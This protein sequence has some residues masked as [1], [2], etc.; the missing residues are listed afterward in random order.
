MRK[1]DDLGFETGLSEIMLHAALRR[2]G[3]QLEAHPEIPGTQNQPDFLVRSAV[4]DRVM[5]VEI[6]TINHAA[7]RAPRDRRE[8]VVFEAMNGARL[9]QDARLSYEVL[10]YGRASPSVNRIRTAVERWATNNVVV[11]RAGKYV[12]QIFPL[13]GWCFRIALLTGFKPRPGGRQIAMSGA[14]NG[15]IVGAPP[16]SDGLRRVLKG[17]RQSTEGSIFPMSSQYSTVQT[18]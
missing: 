5:Y 11:A 15:R 14:L 7:E 17:R 10:S 13:D 18:V 3:F 12:A 9:P 1:G 16:V 8:A 4:G 6:T 2:L